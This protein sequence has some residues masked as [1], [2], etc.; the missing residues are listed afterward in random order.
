MSERR[1]RAKAAA[2][3]FIAACKSPGTLKAY[4]KEWVKWLTFAR[5][6]GYR[7]GPPKPSDLE[8]Y[9]TSEV[10]ARGSVAVLDSISASF[11]WRLCL[12]WVRFPF[13]EQKNCSDRKGNEEVALQAYSTT[14]TFSEVDHQEIHAIFQRF[15]PALEGCS[16]H[17]DIFADFLCFS[18]VLN[19]RLEDITLTRSDLRF[20]VKKAKNHRLGFDVCLPVS[21]SRGIG[22]F[23]LDFLRRGLKWKPGKTSFLCCQLKGGKFRPQLPISYSALHSSCKDRRP[24]MLRLHLKRCPIHRFS[25]TGV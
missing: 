15:F 1:A 2:D 18:E 20:R 4:K 25:M 9:L 17:G 3:K 24:L 11:N 7:L 22:A 5:K 13:S 16:C 10:A 21:D 8:D 14:P 6:H 19:V 23:V 12:G